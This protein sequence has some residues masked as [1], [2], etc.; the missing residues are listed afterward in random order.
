MR[1]CETRNDGEHG[2]ETWI[3]ANGSVG[4]RKYDTGNGTY[5]KPD[6]CMAIRGRMNK[7]VKSPPRPFFPTYPPPTLHRYRITARVY[8]LTT[9]R[10]VQGL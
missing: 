9:S 2:I 10:A 4:S 5:E 7:I 8:T 3:C 6:D 1:E